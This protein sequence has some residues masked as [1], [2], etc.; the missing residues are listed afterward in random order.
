MSAIFT[1]VW[2]I[3]KGVPLHC[4]TSVV[5]LLLQLRATTINQVSSWSEPIIRRVSIDAGEEHY[6]TYSY[7]PG[8]VVNHEI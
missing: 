3:N 2:N 5:L 8:V 6:N 7:Y 1:F 4:T